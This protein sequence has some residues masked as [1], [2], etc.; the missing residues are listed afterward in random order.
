MSRKHR[1]GALARRMLRCRRCGLGRGV[2]AVFGRFDDPRWMLIGQAPGE[3]EAALGRPF[4]GPAG[5]RLFGWLADAGFAEDEFR[6]CCH[7]TSM[8][9]CFPGKGER[10]DLR[11]SRPQL[12]NCS[13]FLAEEIE[14]V[15]PEVLIPVGGLAI[16][17]FLGKRP[18]AE[19]IGRRFLV[20]H[21]GQV[22]AVVPLPHP[23]GA[24]AWTNQQGHSTLLRSALR[25]LADARD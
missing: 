20:E 9:K 18:L 14:L 6:S 25:L 23:S 11:P 21:A 8:M 7:V 24:S 15:R 10:G 17:R 1:F 4:A 16:E 5:R 2:H 3:R 19:V 13:R 22:I 12:E